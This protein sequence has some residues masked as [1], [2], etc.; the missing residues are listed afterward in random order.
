M[1]N[2]GLDECEM[3]ELGFVMNIGRQEGI[4]HSMGTTVRVKYGERKNELRDVVIIKGSINI[5][6]IAGS[7]L[8]NDRYKLYISQYINQR[9][10]SI[11]YSKVQ[12][13]KYK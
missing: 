10:H 2:E 5:F 1:M 13:I 11:K 6:I 12:I 8:Q 9:I 7:F 3:N 4:L